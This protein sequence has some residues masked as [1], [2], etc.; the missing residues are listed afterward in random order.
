[1]EC[2]TEKCKKK[3]K[4]KNKNFLISP[5]LVPDVPPPGVHSFELN[6][7]PCSFEMQILFSSGKY[8]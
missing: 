7:D 3:E 5:S 4:E 6:I 1:M 2:W 8:M